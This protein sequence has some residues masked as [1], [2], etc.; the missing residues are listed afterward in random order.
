MSIAKF[1]S[2]LV[3]STCVDVTHKKRGRP[4]LKAEEASLRPYTAQFDNPVTPAELQQRSTTTPTTPQPTRTHGHKPTPSREIRPVTDLQVSH[5]G[6]GNL[7]RW[8]FSVP[9]SQPRGDT[10]PSLTIGSLGRRPFSSGSSHQ[11]MAPGAFPAA[12]GFNP[13]TLEPSHQLSTAA[14]AAAGTGRPL[15]SYA[16]QAPL[17]PAVSQ[18]QYQQPFV[19]ERIAPFLDRSTAPAPAP[20]LAPMSANWLPISERPLPLSR[21]RCES[22]PESP[23]RLPPILPSIATTGPDSSPSHHV[24][25]F[26]DPYQA[27][28]WSWSLRSRENFSR[29]GQ[30]QDQPRPSSQPGPVEPVSPRTQLHHQSP[31]ES[32]HGHGDLQARHG[33]AIPSLTMP[34]SYQG[35]PLSMAASIGLDTGTTSGEQS[36]AGTEGRDSR[37]IKRRRMSLNDMVN[38]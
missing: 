28:T 35:Q 1:Y 25:R 4:P 16:H 17:L 26:N 22:Y 19:G 15:S 10:S 38:D 31:Y 30:G 32:T 6:T 18:P 11:H 27:P 13:P 8:S 36:K 12:G 24:P 9:P 2:P 3:E 37:P 20:V 23:V 5:G 14:A 29:E 34:T 7:Q 33:G 21:D